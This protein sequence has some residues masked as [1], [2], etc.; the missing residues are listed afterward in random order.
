MAT[1][2]QITAMCECSHHWLVHA[3]SGRTAQS[4]VCHGYIGSATPGPL[5]DPCRCTGFRPWSGPRDSRTGEPV[6][7][8][9]LTT[10]MRASDAINL[11]ASAASLTYEAGLR[12]GAAAER[13]RIIGLAKRNARRQSD[14]WARN[15]LNYL[16]RLLRQ[17]G[18]R[19]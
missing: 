5:Y 11:A 13:E 18:E 2:E 8:L 15:A 16:A 1:P 17:D 19:T 4:A 3:E 9:T 6:R 14:P 12:D 7:A 10:A